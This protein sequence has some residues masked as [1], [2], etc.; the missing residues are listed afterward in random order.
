MRNYRCET[1]ST[2]LAA[3]SSSAILFPSP[4]PSPL[5]RGRQVSCAVTEQAVHDSQAAFCALGGIALYSR[6]KDA[7]SGPLLLPL[8]KGEGWGEGEGDADP[9]LRDKGA[10]R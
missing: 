10:N 9:I 1:Y 7:L 6:E 4:Q 8:P 5:G 3:H 2:S